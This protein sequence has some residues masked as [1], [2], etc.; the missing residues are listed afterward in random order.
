MSTLQS[1]YTANLKATPDYHH[2]K[3]QLWIRKKTPSMQP[4]TH[5]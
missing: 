1:L 4:T 3:P 2:P 5:N